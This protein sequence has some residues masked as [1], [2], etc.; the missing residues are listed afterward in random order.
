MSGPVCTVVVGM[1][2]FIIFFSGDRGS[3]GSAKFYADNVHHSYG[4]G[5]SSNPDNYNQH[6]QPRSTHQS[7]YH[8]YHQPPPG[9]NQP[10]VP[11]NTQKSFQPVPKI[12]INGSNPI[13]HPNSQQNTGSGGMIKQFE[14]VNI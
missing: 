3:R 12:S 7:N 9:N 11:R 10:S 13:Q 1:M 2:T 8:Q 14:S 4:D 5:A 6:S